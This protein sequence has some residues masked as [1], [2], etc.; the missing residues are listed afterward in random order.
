M[1]RVLALLLLLSAPAAAVEPLACTALTVPDQLGL[2]CREAPELA[3]GAVVV[4]PVESSFSA[5]SR[6]LVRPLDRAGEDELAWSDPEA[7]LRKQMTIDT[8]SYA[9]LM[10]GLAENPDSPFAG[11]SAQAAL[12]TFKTALSS[13][14]R[15]ALT[16]CDD[17]A[18]TSPGRWG[19][20]CAFTAGGIGMFMQL[21]VVAE[22]EQRWAMTM[23]AANEQRLRHFEAIGNSFEPG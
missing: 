11:P 21:R 13:V 22:G 16:A 5:L 23:R 12:D 8:S 19:M 1:L 17:P 14:A 9:D 7:W 4:A 10:A 18:L 6:M 20:S 2:G 3:P 15:V